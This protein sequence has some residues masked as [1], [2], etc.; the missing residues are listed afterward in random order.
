[1]ALWWTNGGSGLRT[2]V[3]FLFRPSAYPALPEPNADG[4][5]ADSP[6]V[7]SATRG[8][9]GRLQPTKTDPLACARQT[10]TKGS[11]AHSQK[12][13]PVATP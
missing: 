11:Q 9:A 7:P 10:Q 2:A 13:L 12:S 5:V 8:H 4:A 1:M 3:V 6:L